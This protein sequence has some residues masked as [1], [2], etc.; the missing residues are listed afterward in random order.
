MESVNTGY[1]HSLMS[2]YKA[3]QEPAKIPK[4]EKESKTSIETV[5]GSNSMLPENSHPSRGVR[6]NDQ[7]IKNAQGGGG[8]VHF[9]LHGGAPY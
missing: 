6:V 8:K 3:L 9:W 1:S 5:K 7:T 2:I 4:F